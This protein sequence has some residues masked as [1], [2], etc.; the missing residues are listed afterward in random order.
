MRIQVIQLK[1]L[2]GKYTTFLLILILF[3]CDVLNS[4]NNYEAPELHNFD[5]LGEQ[6]NILYLRKDYNNS[7]IAFDAL[8]EEVLAIY[9]FPNR[10][11][12]QFLVDPKGLGFYVDVS[13][14]ALYHI[15]TV[16][17]EIS[18]LTGFEYLGFNL[19]HD[20]STDDI[21]IS[22]QNVHKGQMYARSISMP[23]NVLGE[24]FPIPD[25]WFNMDM[26][27]SSLKDGL[28]LTLAKE[29]TKSQLYFKEKN[30]QIDVVK[31][32]FDSDTE[33]TALNFLDDKLLNIVFAQNG[34]TS[35]DENLF[36]L[37]KVHSFDPIDLDLIYQMRDPFN[38]FLNSEEAYF[39]F[40]NAES[41]GMYIRKISH[42]GELLLDPVFL[43][44][45]YTN[46]SIGEWNNQYYVLAYD[47]SHI[48]KFNEDL[49]GTE[50]II[51]VD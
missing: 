31:D 49:E 33:Y 48:L 26:A 38:N 2:Q 5:P 32:Y 1:R 19:V 9:K 24:I 28:V 51:N 27:N 8:N 25:P 11:M 14:G 36:K 15:N 37:F 3:S 22:G 45:A 39:I 23:G 4:F 41:P 34:N 13:P 29:S 12:S 40:S 50:I 17:G 16:T 21:Y 20:L 35:T 7:I 6:D 42:D 10:I 47:G 44:D 46:A 18:S 43:S 30:T